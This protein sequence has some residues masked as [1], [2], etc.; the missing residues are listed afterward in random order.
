MV[1]TLKASIKHQQTIKMQSGAIGYFYSQIHQAPLRI[2][3]AYLV[4]ANF[5][6]CTINTKLRNAIGD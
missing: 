4:F 1:I 5:K 2:E 3:I 6:Q